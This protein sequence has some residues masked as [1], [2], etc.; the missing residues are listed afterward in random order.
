MRSTVNSLLPGEQEDIRQEVKTMIAEPAKWLD[1]PN[2]RLGGQKPGD[3]IGTEREQL[4]R[5]LLRALKYG[6]FT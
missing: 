1:T 2:D 3:L 5:D 4:V 6:L